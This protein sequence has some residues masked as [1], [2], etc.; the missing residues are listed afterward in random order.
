MENQEIDE[1]I[2]SDLGVENDENES[3]EE[4]NKTSAK[5]NN[6]N[7]KALYKSNKEKETLLA[8]RES[9]LEEAREE[10][11]QWRELNPD[12]VEDLN[13]KKDIDS[14]KEEIFTTK[15]PDAEPH[16]KEIRKT[17]LD[18]NMDLKTA[19]KF[20]KMDMPEE[21]KSNSEFNIWKNAI[22]TKDLSKVSPE[23]ALNLSPEKQREWRKI[24]LS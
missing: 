3:G 20:V 8:E 19:W 24:N 4:E 16:L 12:T 10:L 1:E 15:N 6:S 17:M 18:Y 13:S 9:E 11:K 23:D 21:S 14:M 2:N 22:S 5:K 7:F